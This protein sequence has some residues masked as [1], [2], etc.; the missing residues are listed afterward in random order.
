MNTMITKTNSTFFFVLVYRLWNVI[1][2]IFNNIENRRDVPRKWNCC[3]MLT[4]PKD[5]ER[6]LL[7]Y[8]FWR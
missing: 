4:A 3:D 5:L 6:H 7:E 1:K 2:M 8:H